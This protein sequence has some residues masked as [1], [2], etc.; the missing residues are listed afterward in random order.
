MSKAKLDPLV[1]G[2]P[3]SVLL[4]AMTPEQEYVDFSTTKG[5]LRLVSKSHRVELKYEPGAGDNDG[6]AETIDGVSTLA[7]RLSA[8]WTRDEE[9]LPVTEPTDYDVWFV[10]GELTGANAIGHYIDTIKVH[11]LRDGAP[12]S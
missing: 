7:F 3:W 6:V 4:D 5:Y 9:N 11:P 8:E 1:T 12:M 10:V 2:L